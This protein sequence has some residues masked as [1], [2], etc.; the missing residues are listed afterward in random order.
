M[1]PWKNL[2]PTLVRQRLIIEGTTDLIVGP[3]Q[4]RKYL[5]ALAD[6]TGMEKLSAPYVYS[7][8]EMGWGAWI[9]W[10]TS[11]ATFYS[12]PTDPPF[13]SVDCYTCKPFDAS[14]AAEFTKEFLHAVDLVWQEVCV[15]LIAGDFFP[16]FFVYFCQKSDWQQTWDYYNLNVLLE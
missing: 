8:H 9:H 6:V 5:D 14:L 2:A 13:F 7:A 10:K 12:Y 4:I 3:D 16:G 1:E 15:W 11:G